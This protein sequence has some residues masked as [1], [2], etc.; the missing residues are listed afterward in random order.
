MIN[1]LI[2]LFFNIINICF[3][4]MSRVILL[5]TNSVIV[6]QGN[7]FPLTL[8]KVFKALNKVHTL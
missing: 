2:V 8:F 7:S 1:A 5:L 6:L 4:E 3:F